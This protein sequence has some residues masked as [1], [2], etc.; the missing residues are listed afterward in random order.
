MECSRHSK[1]FGEVALELRGNR[2][3]A[4]PVPF[5]ASRESMRPLETEATTQS[6][7]WAGAR[8]AGLRGLLP[9]RPYW[10]QVRRP[11]GRSYSERTFCPSDVDA[12]A[13]WF[14]GAAGSCLYLGLA[15]V[16]IPAIILRRRSSYCGFS[17]LALD[18]SF[19][20]T[21]GGFHGV[22]ESVVMEFTVRQSSS[23]AGNRCLTR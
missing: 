15:R 5:G 9:F 21:Q 16:F 10:I 13:R 11:R 2:A 22:I 20:L 18:R 12:G 17:N 4:P 8:S 6:I 1:Q 3:A 19:E 14:A 23:V 7:A